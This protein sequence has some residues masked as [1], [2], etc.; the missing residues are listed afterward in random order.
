MDKPVTAYLCAAFLLIGLLIGLLCGIQIGTAKT[1]Q[2][3]QPTA[4]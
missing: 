1:H 3:H 2:F 4:R